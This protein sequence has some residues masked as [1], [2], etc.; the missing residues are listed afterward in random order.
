MKSA[1]TPNPKPRVG[2]QM[3]AAWATHWVW[4]CWLV[5][6]LLA[7]LSSPGCQDSAAVSLAPTSLVVPPHS[8]A[9]SILCPWP[10]TCWG[11]LELSPYCVLF[12]YRLIPLLISSCLGV[13]NA[14]QMP[15][16][17]MY[18]S[19]LDLCPDSWPPT[20]FSVWMSKTL[21]LTFNTSN[22]ELLISSHLPVWVGGCPVFPVT[23]AR[24]LC[25]SMLPFS[26][27]LYIQFVRKL[28]FHG[29]SASGIWWL[30]STPLLFHPSASHFHPCL[31]KS[32]LSTAVR[33]S[34]Y[35]VAR[36]CCSSA[37]T[38]PRLLLFTWNASQ[39]PSQILQSPR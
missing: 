15:M 24:S 18:T 11:V 16:T 34:L 23:W 38:L 19:S 7:A 29:P 1:V 22:A 5:S 33:R 35:T 9:G 13:L 25:L 2:W 17:P 27:A 36:L 21:L 39:H 26:P 14:L 30:L 8:L 20:R 37:Q 6:L 10:W 28:S 31:C 32:V 4:L 3:S 12:Y